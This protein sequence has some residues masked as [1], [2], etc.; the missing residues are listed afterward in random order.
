MP[1]KNSIAEMHE[2]ITKWRRHLHENPELMFDV[3]D[4]AAFV[5]DR[6]KEFGVDEITP[7]IGQTGLLAHS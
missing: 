1:V 3:H 5:Q 2:D 6:L 7:G 4:T